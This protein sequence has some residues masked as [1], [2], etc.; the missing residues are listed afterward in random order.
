[1]SSIYAIEANEIGLINHLHEHIVEVI[2]DI[3]LNNAQVGNTSEWVTPKVYK[4]FLPEHKAPN[5]REKLARNINQISELKS[6][7]IEAYYPSV[8]IKLMS[9][10]DDTD[11]EN[12]IAYTDVKID[13]FV[14]VSQVETDERVEL[15]IL[16][17]RKIRNN[18]ANLRNGWINKQYALQQPIDSQFDDNSAKPQFAIMINTTWRYNRPSAKSI[19][20]IME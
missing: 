11:K 2:E 20:N 16:T 6:P 5:E 13:I 15:A 19:L 17:A 10:T 7:D 12:N 3:Q 9:S 14:L 1:M 4:Y 18:L 8:L